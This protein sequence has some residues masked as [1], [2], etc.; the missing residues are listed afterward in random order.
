MLIY[1]EANHAT[2]PVTL[3]QFSFWQQTVCLQR[4]RL[5]SVHNLLYS[6]SGLLTKRK[7]IQHI[8]HHVAARLLHVVQNFNLSKVQLVY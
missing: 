5:I 4:A 8:V 1:A 3:P 7:N 2:K 6:R